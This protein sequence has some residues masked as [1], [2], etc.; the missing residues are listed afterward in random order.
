MSFMKAQRTLITAAAILAAASTIDAQTLPAGLTYPAARRGTQVDD[1]HGTKISDPYRWLED[2]DSPETRAWVEAENKLTFGYLA[3]IP[4]R[5]AI[6]N[7]LTQVWN[8][9]KYD[10][11][12]KVDDRLFFSENSG[13]LNQSILYVKDGNKASRVLLDPNTLST[14]GTVALS[15]TEPSPNGKLLGYAVQF[16]GS[17]WQEIRVRDVESARD[18]RDTLKWVKFSGISWTR[19]NKGFFYEGYDPQTSGNKLTNVVRNQRIYYHKIGTPQSADLIVYDRKDQPDWLFDTQVT[20][21]GTFAIITI[22]Q[23]SDPKTR[24]Y[25][26]FLDN[27]KKPSITAPVVRLIDDTESEN[28]FIDNLGDYFLVRTDRGAPKGQVVQ[29]DI[30][31]SDPR[32]WVSVIPEGRDALVSSHVIG[33]HLV[34][35]YLQDAHSS[36]RI[37]GLPIDRPQRQAD[38]RVPP[39]GIPP[40]RQGRT[41]APSDDRRQLSAP[42][43]P[44]V[45]EI[46]LP[47]LG[48]VGRITGREDDNEMYYSFT[49]FLAPSSIYKYDMK[50][51]TNELFKTPKLP[52]DV[53]QFETRQV[54]FESKD[55]T[56]VPMFIT[57]K[58]GTVL[59]GANPTILYGYGGFNVAETPSFSAANL[60]WMEMG[61]IYAV[62][63][64]RGGSEYGKAW[65]EAGM[66][67]KKQNV[68][69]DFIAA[70]EYLIKEKYTSTPRLAISGGSN[71]G[72][73]VGAVL[74]Q[75][76]DL[77]GAALPAVG[78]MDMLRFQKFT[79]GWAWTSDY[80]SSDNPQEFEI[81]RAYSPLHNIKPGTKYPAT[82]ITTADHDDRVVPGHSFKYAATLQA[83][84]AGSAPVLIRI[85][86]NAGH[87]AGKP[88]SKRIEEAADRFAFL[89]KNLGMRVN[90]Q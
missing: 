34:L 27:P 37:Y 2:T 66:L 7:R 33:K 72:L 14:D 61:G 21:D 73:L 28:T 89:V 71:G 46:Q 30:N 87:G 3:A 17:D 29:I 10:T 54:F 50:K 40:Q 81:L 63:N 41:P 55:G 45:D 60:V 31:N 79:I 74:N 18:M 57:M 8:Y 77:F 88:T 25:F 16:A 26:I 20:D 32:R 83:A 86:T 75:R 84:Q 13:L 4:E 68:F 12:T 64:I 22:N 38:R 69:D 43:Y 90:V 44:F 52:V 1:Y 62:A 56:R 59:D 9:P 5:A 36:L 67:D 53:S 6:R 76:P 51:R 65:H 35:E 85:E 42:G 49:S 39:T 11:P 82:L 23:G 78:V 47:G 80:G 24:L 19:D 58:K 15:I 48:S 70:A